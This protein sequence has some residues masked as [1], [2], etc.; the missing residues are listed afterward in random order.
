MK[1]KTLNCAAKI[2]QKLAKGT[3]EIYYKNH[4]TGGHTKLGSIACT[5]LD[6]V[7]GLMQGHVWSP[8]GQASDLI[9]GLGLSH[10]SMSVGDLIK[11]D[12]VTFQVEP[13]GFKQI[14]EEV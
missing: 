4:K 10:T 1:Y 3:T 2:S 8:N 13:I 11:V 12:G 7:Y 6:V 5:D 14:D 9:D